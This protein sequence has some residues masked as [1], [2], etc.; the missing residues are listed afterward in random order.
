MQILDPVT[1]APHPIKG[2]DGK[3]STSLP[4]NAIA[5]TPSDATVYDPPI[6]VW[7]GDAGSV[8][9]TIVPYGK[10]GDKTVLY[11]T[12]FGMILPVLCKQV[13]LTGTTATVLRGQW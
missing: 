4:A 9:V 6:Q 3:L 12:A 5:I 13:M 7:V 10:K 8:N 1:G 11:P 2:V